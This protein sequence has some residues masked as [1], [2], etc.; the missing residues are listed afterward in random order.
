MSIATA[1]TERLAPLR[2]DLRVRA[3]AVVAGVVVAVG[4]GTTHWI[5]FVI[6]G[7]IAGLGQRD[8]LRGVGAGLLVGVLAWLVFA[9]LLAVNGTL[10]SALG[11]GR[12][13]YVS[14]A[15]PLVFGVLG[16]LIR[17]IV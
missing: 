9:L 13:L 14:V 15:I 10:D 3:V 17:G 2:A 1:T 11:M 4:L 5:G 7:G 8:L 16:G 12:I 6:G